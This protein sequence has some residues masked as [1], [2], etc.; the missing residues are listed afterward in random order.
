MA[1]KKELTVDEIQAVIKQLDDFVSNLN[2]R[3]NQMGQSGSSWFSFSSWF[4]LG[5]SKLLAG[6]KFIIQSLD[7]MIQFVEDLIPSGPDKKAAVLAMV[8]QLYDKV[9]SPALPIWL[10]PFSGTIK[11]IIV[12]HLIANLIDFVVGKYNSGVWKQ[13]VNNDQQTSQTN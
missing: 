10:K 1:D 9:V 11:S 8:G 4:S 3:W 13:D 6:T 5:T 2:N 12:D 7:Q